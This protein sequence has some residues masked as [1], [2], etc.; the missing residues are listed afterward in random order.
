[1]LYFPTMCVFPRIMCNVKGTAPDHGTSAWKHQSY[2][3]RVVTPPF[4]FYNSCS[5]VMSTGACRCLRFSNEPSPNPESKNRKSVPEQCWLVRCF[6]SSCPYR[7]PSFPLILTLPA[8]LSVGFHNRHI[9]HQVSCQSEIPWWIR[10]ENKAFQHSQ[11]SCSNWMLILPIDDSS[12]CWQTRW[13]REMK[14]PVKAE[15]QKL[16]AWLSVQHSGHHDRKHT[17]FPSTQNVMKFLLQ[18]K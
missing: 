5:H 16:I 13:V 18:I 6:S 2:E 14:T 12:A 15:L 1:M 17:S 8:C 3:S 9:H 7:F 10:D 11:T 4:Y